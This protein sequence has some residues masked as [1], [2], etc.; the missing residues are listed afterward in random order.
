[1]AFNI[2]AVSGHGAPGS[3]GMDG[4]ADPTNDAH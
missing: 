3:H 2:E 1:M 4:M